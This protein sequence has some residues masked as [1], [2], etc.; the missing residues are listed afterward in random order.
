MKNAITLLLLA[1]M[2]APA[3]AQSTSQQAILDLKE[4]YL[5]VNLIV[6]QR[7]I[8]ALNDKGKTK[9]AEAVQAQTKKINDSV[10][11]AFSSTYTFSKMLF[12]YSTDLQAFNGGD[13]SV[14]FDKAGEAPGQVPT[15]FL[16]VEYGET[17]K[18]GINGFIVKDKN[19][20]IIKK[21]FFP[22]FISEYQGTDS[23]AFMVK[24]LNKKFGEYYS[25]AAD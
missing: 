10:I 21:D 18:R 9:E 13:A 17:P 1:I 5:V 22:Y 8:D 25:Y 16:Y 19:R 3:F 23:F 24:K 4:G 14:L 11:D 12:V 6:P 7:K 2:S 15:K 20:E